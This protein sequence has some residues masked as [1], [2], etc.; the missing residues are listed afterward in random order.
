M[1]S[2][3]NLLKATLNRLSIRIGKQIFNAASDIAEIAQDAPERIKDEWEVLKEEIVN[4]ARRLDQE[5]NETNKSPRNA[6]EKQVSSGE[7]SSRIQQI[8]KKISNLT[9]EIEDRT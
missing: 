5:E 7:A 4:E 9:I 1:S 6:S 3:E 2:S 8:R